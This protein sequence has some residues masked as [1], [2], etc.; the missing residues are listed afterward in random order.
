MVRTNRFL[1]VTLSIA[2]SM[3]LAHGGG[4][5]EPLSALAAGVIAG[6]IAG[7]VCWGKRDRLPGSVAACALG[8]AGLMYIVC[9]GPSESGAS[10]TLRQS[11]EDAAG[12]WLILALPSFIVVLVVMLG[13]ASAKKLVSENKAGNGDNAS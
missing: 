4:F 6:F 5:R 3:A 10:R 9:L 1:A 11:A 7:V 12:N 2:P 13:L 8:L